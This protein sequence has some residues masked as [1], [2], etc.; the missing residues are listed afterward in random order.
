M[1][2]DKFESFAKINM[3]LN[4]IKRLP[5]KYHKIES[6]IAFVKLSDHIKIRSNNINLS[7]KTCHNKTLLK[8]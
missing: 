5:N 4:V 1:K 2:F 6:L 7:L 8:R 3:S